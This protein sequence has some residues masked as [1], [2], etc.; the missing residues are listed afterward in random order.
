MLE[1]VGDFIGN[2]GFPVAVATFVLWRL[3]GKLDRLTK[4][5]DRFLKHHLK[6][7]RREGALDDDEVGVLEELE[8]GKR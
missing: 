6:A 4:S 1:E 3:N 2:V 7:R 5:L 8:N